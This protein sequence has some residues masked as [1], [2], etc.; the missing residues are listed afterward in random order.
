MAGRQTEGKG[1]FGEERRKIILHELER[2][3]RVLVNDLCERFG[4]SKS[5]LRNDLHMLEHEGLLKRTYGGAVVL[6]RHAYESPIED[7][8]LLNN[9]SKRAIGRCAA[10]LV[11]DGDTMFLDSGSTVME[12]VRACAG[13]RNLTIFT[14]DLSIAAEAEKV[15]VDCS[16]VFLG[17]NLRQGYH[18]MV[19]SMLVEAASRFNAP[20]V[21]LGTSGFTPTGGFTVATTDSASYKRVMIERSERRILLLDSSKIGKNA[22]VTFATLEDIDVVITDSSIS[23]SARQALQGDGESESDPILLLA[24]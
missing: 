16:L 5:T 9:D 22:T 3:G 18:Y 11:K 21:F 14:S 12:F 2:D 6:E 24:E 4:M 17:G 8:L 15:L 20:M 23:S 13:K 19:G 7:S 10:G 1:M